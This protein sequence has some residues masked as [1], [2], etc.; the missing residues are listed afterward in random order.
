M[1]STSFHRI[2]ADRGSL[3]YKIFAKLVHT[4]LNLINNLNANKNIDTRIKKL[5]FRTNKFEEQYPKLEKLS[6]PSRKL[7][8]LFWMNLDWNNLEKELGE[9]KICDIGC[10]SGNYFLK[11]LEFSGNRIKK[12]TGLDIV[13]NK[14]WE[15]LKSIYSTVNFKKYDG[16]NM[17]ALIPS[18]TNL[19]ISQSAIEHFLEDITIF[20]QL[21]DFTLKTEQKVNQIHLF[22]SKACIKLYPF[23]GVRQYTPKNISKITRLFFS[24]VSDLEL[25]EL[26]SENTYKAHRDFINIGLF[27]RDLRKR[28]EGIYEQTCY[29]AIK[30]DLEKF[31]TNM[32]NFYALVIKNRTYD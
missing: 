23:H 29:K 21:R 5:Y 18:D 28:D 31:K 22:P 3:L 20:K 15:K 16:K 11:L 19:I 7:S 32:P 30:D 6:S 1:K 27:K 2:T 9:L 10:G 14:N 13:R 25:Y 24:K 12:Y 4:P 17:F 8:D 26:G